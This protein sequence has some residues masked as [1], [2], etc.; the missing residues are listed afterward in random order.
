MTYMAYIFIYYSYL[1]LNFFRVMSENKV[2]GFFVA[3]TA[4]R[5]IKLADPQTIEGKKYNIDRYLCICAYLLYI[6]VDFRS[7]ETY[8]ILHI[9]VVVCPIQI[10]SEN[11]LHHECIHTSWGKGFSGS[12]PTVKFFFLVFLVLTINLTKGVF[13]T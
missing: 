11:P 4:L 8:Y 1:L 9:V 10:Q 12:L 13:F 6:S 3:P 5:A 2:N 7:F